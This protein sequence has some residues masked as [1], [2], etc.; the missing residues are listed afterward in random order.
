MRLDDKLEMAAFSLQETISGAVAGVRS[1]ARD[2]SI[3][4]RTEIEPSEGKIVGNQFSIEEM[5]TNLLLN[6]IKYTPKSGEI[7]LS[8]KSQKDFVSID[9][10]D[11]GIG[12]PQKELPKIFDEFYRAGNAR[13][14]ERDGTGLGL[15]IVKQ[16][17][18]RHGGEI[19]VESKED[20]G[21]TF[22]LTLPRG[23]RS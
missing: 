5:I 18:E 17:V 3:D 14:V 10:T 4:L 9:V 1:K 20:C 23:H 21:A 11:T 6:A 12:I 22:R 16:I 15:S 2:K 7:V 13:R 8:M 19:S